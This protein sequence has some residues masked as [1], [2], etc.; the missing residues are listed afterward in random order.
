M[1]IAGII[2]EYDPFHKG[3]AAHIAATRAADGGSATHIVAVMSGSFTQRGEPAILSK[4]HR[5]EMALLGGAD[6]V[7]ELPLPWA[8]APAENFAS[9]GVALLNAL[10]C[11]DLISFGSECGDVAL[12]RRLA[13]LSAHPDYQ[14][15]LQHQLQSGIPY[16]AAGQAAA[17][18]VLGKAVALALTSPNNT[19]GI[20]YLRAIQR[21]G[22]Q[23]DA[24]TLARQ[25]AMHNEHTPADGIT[26]ASHIRR[27]L[28]AGLAKEATA[29][30]PDSAGNSLIKSIAAQRAPLD[31]TKIEAIIPAVLRKM[32]EDDFAQLPWLSE[33]LEN[34]LYK[35]SRT[36]ADYSELI[37]AVKTKRYPA[38]R[39]RRIVWS[40]VLGITAKDVAGLPPYVRVLAMNDRGREILSV[41]SSTLPL[42]TK[43]SQ[44]KNLDARANRTFQLETVAT[45]IHALGMPHP[46]ICGADYSNKLIVM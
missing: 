38:A 21:Q 6:L 22:A 29:Y 4:F 5:A 34:R 13:D 44:L 1:R 8:M 12:L 15:E 19:L 25:G 17:T 41:A 11:V 20:E 14:K 30:M 24:Y 43:S 35:A 45:D 2:A 23:M 10:G 18:A 46:Q 3:H 28:R 31:A 7:I 36:A 32:T 42:L 37:E 40:A 27:L 9:G 26:S 39:L 16:A 33:G